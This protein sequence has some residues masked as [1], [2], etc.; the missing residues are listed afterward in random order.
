MPSR[1]S[2]REGWDFPKDVCTAV[3]A[4]RACLV[5]SA[6]PPAA[7]LLAFGGLHLPELLSSCLVPRDRG[8][9]CRAFGDQL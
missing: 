9:F 2:Q 6:V 4:A 3:N 8:A 5:P 1:D 7:L